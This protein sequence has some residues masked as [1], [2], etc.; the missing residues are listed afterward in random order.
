MGTTQRPKATTASQATAPRVLR[1]R[2]TIGGAHGDTHFE[3]GDTIDVPAH[4]YDEW[5]AAGLIEPVTGKS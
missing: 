3:A 1:C 2:S 4:K 5:L